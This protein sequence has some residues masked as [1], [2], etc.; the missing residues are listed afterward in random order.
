MCAPSAGNVKSPSVTP[1][2]KVK[3]KTHLE[4]RPQPLLEFILSQD[5]PRTHL[6]EDRV[7]FTAATYHGRI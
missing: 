1:D 5:L 4:K 3:L 2:G 7:N 6:D